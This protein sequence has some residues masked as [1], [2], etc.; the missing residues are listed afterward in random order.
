[1]DNSKRN[2]DVYRRF[3]KGMK[4]RDK[5][6]IGDAYNATYAPGDM[7][8]KISMVTKGINPDAVDKAPKIVKQIVDRVLEDQRNLDKEV[9]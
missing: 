8:K 4:K 7:K 9:Y 5:K 2:R 6:A 3:D 1:M